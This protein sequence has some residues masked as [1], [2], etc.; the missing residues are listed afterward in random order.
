MHALIYGV[1]VTQ[2]GEKLLPAITPDI[3]SLVS[4][5]K[6]CGL[7]I[8]LWINI[9]DMVTEQIETIKSLGIVILP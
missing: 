8:V 7:S 2:A 3:P 5:V 4:D 9:N 6:A 1:W